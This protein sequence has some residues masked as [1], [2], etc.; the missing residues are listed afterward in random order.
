MSAITAQSFR[1]PNLSFCCVAAEARCERA[2]TAWQFPEVWTRLC[3]GWLQGKGRGQWAGAR[4]ATESAAWRC[5]VPD[6]DRQQDGVLRTAWFQLGPTCS[7][8]KVGP[9]LLRTAAAL[10]NRLQCCQHWGGL[11]FSSR[12]DPQH[13][14]QIDTVTAL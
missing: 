9:L 3:A 14:N 8:A 2:T 12:L 5:G 10:G 4:A 1:E 11:M 7:G 6:N 13:T